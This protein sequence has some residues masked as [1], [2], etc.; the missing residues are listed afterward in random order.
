MIYFDPDF[1]YYPDILKCCIKMIFQIYSGSSPQAFV[2]WIF[3]FNKLELDC[4]KNMK[5]R[6]TSKNYRI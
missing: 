3:F 5:N 1:Y 6:T 4:N 2:Y